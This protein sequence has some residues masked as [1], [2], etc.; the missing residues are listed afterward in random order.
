MCTHSSE[1]RT[2]QGTW[3]TPELVKAVEMGY[4]VVKIHEV[5]HFPDEQ[6]KT[7]LFSSYVNT[8]LKIKQESG[9]WPAWVSTEEDKDRYIRDY[10]AKEGIKM[11]PT[12]IAKNP[13]RKATAKLMLNSFW[14]KFGERMNKPKTEQITEPHH[15]F[16]LVSDPL[17]RIQCVR[18]H[19]EDV[20]EVVYTSSA[21]D[22]PRGFK[23][24]IFVAAFTTSQARLKIYESLEKVDKQVL[25][26]DTDSVVYKW[27]PGLPEI[28]LGDYLGDMT[29][30]LDDGDHIVEFVSGGAKNY[31]Y[32]T[33]NGKVCCKVRGFTLNVRG[34]KQLNYDVMRQNIL[35]EI[36]H[37]L[38]D[39]RNTDVLNPYHFTREPATK[40]LKTVPRI[41][42]YG[43][44]FD[45]R[46]VDP[47]TFSSFPY[48]YSPLR[49]EDVDNIEMLI[50]L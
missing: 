1:Q 19:N 10:E 34:L 48:G 17:L 30:E 45:K 33:K 18:I 47:T 11:D 31:G 44:V 13:G 39:R 7:G 15:L 32:M 16:Q 2:L 14:G 46:V 41:K 43:L 29:N 20:L 26:Y 42:K 9:G 23:T 49:Q 36:R 27:R 40:R 35:E 25:Y 5:W 24:N 22:A 12:M 21:E 8:W 4:E 50:D 3:C 28:E 37:P 38:D 6:R